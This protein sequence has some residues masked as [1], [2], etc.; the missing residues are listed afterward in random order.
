MKDYCNSMPLQPSS[1]GLLCPLLESVHVLGQKETVHQPLGNTTPFTFFLH[2]YVG[3][4][5]VWLVIQLELGLPRLR[6]LGGG[7]YARPDLR[8][9]LLYGDAPR[10]LRGNL[11]HN[12]PRIGR[13]LFGNMWPLSDS[14]GLRRRWGGG[15]EASD[16]G[17]EVA[18]LLGLPSTEHEV[19]DRH[20]LLG[21]Y[22]S[23][24]IGL[25]VK[26]VGDVNS[27]LLG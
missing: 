26:K 20:G 14:Y 27:C 5:G 3:A 6:S 8:L 21:H 23:T 24:T 15:G 25:G 7:R 4:H 18:L 22:V 13:S 16:L 11:S 2:P 10:W 12:I 1:H 9:W 19:V 17:P